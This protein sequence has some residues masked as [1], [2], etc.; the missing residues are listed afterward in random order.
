MLS[1][2]LA[3]AQA[4]PL[5]V[6]ALGKRPSPEG[7]LP[8]RR[9]ALVQQAELEPALQPAQPAQAQPVQGAREAA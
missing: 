7:E 1:P 3:A 5:Q 4:A 2:Q 8:A 9:V 6:P